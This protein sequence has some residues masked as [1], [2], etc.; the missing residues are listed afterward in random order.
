VNA[1]DAR[2]V[3]ARE[4]V[5]AAGLLANAGFPAQAVSRAYFA[6]FYAAEAA[7]MHLGEAPS[8]HAGVIAAFARLVVRDGGCDERA[9][10]LLRDLFERRG[11]ADYSTDP[12]PP[13]E[14]QRAVDDA[15]E[16]V[17]IIEEWLASRA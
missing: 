15:D 5:A 2:L 14:A 6:A 16:V 9:G 8:K 1:R 12:V 3:R 11:Q 10:Q 13:G 7:L 4:E 17:R